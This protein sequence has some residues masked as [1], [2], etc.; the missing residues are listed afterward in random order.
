MNC[1][2]DHPNHRTYRNHRIGADDSVHRPRCDDA[3]RMW[4]RRSTSTPGTKRSTSTRDNSSPT[5][6]DAP[7]T[8]DATV[9]DTSEPIT[10]S[11]ES[12]PEPVDLQPAVDE[13]CDLGRYAGLPTPDGTIESVGARL[14]FLDAARDS[15]PQLNALDV[16]EE[17][18]PSFK[19]VTDA[20]AAADVAFNAAEQAAQAGDVATA[21]TYIERYIAHLW[22]QVGRIALTGY[23]CADALADRASAAD[24][25]VPLDLE[26][27]SSTPVSDRSG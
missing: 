7:T 27:S 14:A 10:A 15:T 11:T 17:E 26:P 8:N 24:L 12:A 20:A 9:A 5:P 2:Q 13:M 1:S 4:Q 23:N 18:Q 22:S 21:E 16:P 6:T 3:G 25:N 19:L